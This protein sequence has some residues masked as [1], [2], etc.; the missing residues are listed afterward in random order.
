MHIK[1]KKSALSLVA[2]VVLFTGVM[3][4]APSGMLPGSL[5]TQKAAACTKMWK[6]LWS[7]A[8]IYNVPNGDVLAT[9]HAGDW[10]YGPA[11]VD[12]TGWAPVYYSWMEDGFHGPVI[13]NTSWMRRDAVQY[14]GCG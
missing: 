6:V 7:V 8:G 10:L 14:M 1:L 11:G 5:G 12:S 2:M 9:R 4:A 13:H 3:A